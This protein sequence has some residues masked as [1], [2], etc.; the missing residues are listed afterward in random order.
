MAKNILSENVCING[1]AVNLITEK[2]MRSALMAGK[3]TIFFIFLVAFPS[4]GQLQQRLQGIWVWEDG[5]IVK[6]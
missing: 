4:F 5:D 1:K 2:K 3:K 6:S